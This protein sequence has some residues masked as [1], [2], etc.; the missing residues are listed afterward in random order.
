MAEVM[1]KEMAEQE[2]NAWLDRKKIFK[3]I[4]ETNKDYIDTLVDAM[5][6]GVLSLDQE[7]WEWNHTLLFPI[8]ENESVKSIKYKPRLND[9]ML[10]PFLNGVK[11]QDS[12]GRLLA[13]V[14]ALTNTPR[15]VLASLDSADKRISMSV[16]IFFL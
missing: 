16:A 1:T 11:N 5:C 10:K 3:S 9:K 15:E 13:H 6:E 2:V 7:T 8:G 12:D 4:R 14:A